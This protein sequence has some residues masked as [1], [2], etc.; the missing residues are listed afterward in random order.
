MLIVDGHVHITNRVYW[1]GID[2][3]IPQAQGFDFARAAECGVGVVIENVAPYGFSTYNQT[4]R[5][6]LRL[7]ETFHRMVDANKH[8]MGL[9]VTADDAREIVASGR[10]AVFLGVEAGFDHEGDI[11]VL[12]AFYRLGVRAIQFST[13]SCFN[14]CGDINDGGDI[15]HWGG[16][17]PHGR[18]L[19]HEMNRLGVLVDI[20]HASRATMA[21]IVDASDAPVTASHLHC[22]A[23]S[24]G[25]G[26]DDDLIR[27]LAAKGGVIG[28]HGAAARIG[29]A[30]REWIGK[31]Q[32]AF[33]A[34]SD[35]LN[36]MIRYR[37]PVPRSA[38]DSNFGMF[39]RL[40]DKEFRAIHAEVFQEWSDDP[41]AQRHIPG[42]AHWAEHVRH[43]VNLVGPAHVGIG[44]DLFGSRSS[45]IKNA[46][47]YAELVKALDPIG[48]PAAVALIAGENWL[49]LLDQVQAQAAPQ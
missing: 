24:G 46:G 38:D 32:D 12:R 9:A 3:W 20:T 49:N 22:A 16:L 5:Q 18:K 13:Q 48:D 28:I 44:L 34:R 19:L 35:R 30:Y 41:E 4:P 2:P 8:R 14:A 7:I 25:D 43:I 37:P 45:V 15:E 29:V 23:V 27:K 40:I 10:L 39:G 11:D 31:N 33:M 1:E 17:S 26:L 36:R 42:P 6:T 21:Q 47:G